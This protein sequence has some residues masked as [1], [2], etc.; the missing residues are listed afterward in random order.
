MFFNKRYVDKISNLKKELCDETQKK[1]H[2]ISVLKEEIITLKLK[3]D[4]LETLNKNLEKDLNNY[5]QTCVENAKVN[6]QTKVI[7]EWL[8]GE[9]K[10]E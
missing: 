7:N 10:G 3:N 2:E 4:E 6:D 9:K 1:D 5:K 8:F